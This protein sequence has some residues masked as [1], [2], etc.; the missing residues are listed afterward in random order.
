M[1]Y[2]GF[3]YGGVAYAG[4]TSNAGTDA[5]PALAVEVAFTTDPL[6]EPLW[7][8]ITSDVRS[9]ETMRGR[10]RELERFQPGRATIV[11]ANREA[12]YDSLNASGPHYGNLRPMK[13]IRI[14]ETFNGVT[15]P[16]FDGFVDKWQLDYP[17]LNKDSIAVL[18][19][20][21]G[22]KVWAR[23][24]MGRSVY[25]NEV[26]ADA[27]VLWWHL[28][29]DLG[30][31][32]EG[33]ALNSGSL[34]ANGNGTFVASPVVGGQALVVKDGGSSLQTKSRTA[35][36][37]I[38]PQGVIIDNAYLNL[39]GQSAWSVEG[40]IRLD[41]TSGDTHVVWQVS[42]PAVENPHAG[43]SYLN[44]GGDASTGFL[45][46]VIF[47]SAFTLGY[48]VQTAAGSILPDQTHHV[49]CEV[50]S[51]G[52]MVIFLDGN[53]VTTLATGA[54]ASTISG[55]TLPTGGD[56][57]LAHEGVA[58]PT[59]TVNFRG[60]SDEFAVYFSALAETRVD[61]HYAAGTAPWQGDSP[62]TRIGRALDLAEWP[63]TLRELDT[64]LTTFQSAEIASQ[65]VL[66][67]SQKSAES[68]YAGL[69][70]VTRD[71]KA[72]FVG[73]TAVF[74]RQPYAIPFGDSAG[75]VGYSGL[76]P[77]DGDEVI[78]NRAKVS[79]LNGAVRT[80]EDTV[81]ISEFSPFEFVLDGLLHNSEQGSTDYAFF[82]VDQYGE[83]RR[84]IVKLE[85]LT[86]IPGDEDLH[87]PAVLGVE[88]GDAITVRNNPIGGQAF[89]QVC[90]IEGIRQF[91]SPGGIHE[92]TFTLSPELPIR[93]LEDED[94]ATLG[95][96]EV[97][98]NQTG[99][100]TSATDLTNLS[101]TVTVGSGRRIRITGH[102]IFQKDTAAGYI[103]MP[104]REGATQL[105]EG[106]ET[107]SAALGFVTFDSSAVETPS[108]GSHTYKLMA[109]TENN[110][111]SLQASALLPAFILVEDIGPA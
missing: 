9:W 53:R 100:G 4:S 43:C 88:L 59:G 105:N 57:T 65:S 36:E 40:W 20:T 30:K 28:D 1:S 94:V 55:V 107:V 13:R 106:I 37:F 66:E 92:T 68:E 56:L 110:T 46:F 5:K 58:T 15:Y 61:A 42:D 109:M 25:A 50:E 77:D 17:G 89:E 60:L 96:A 83:Q 70:F 41:Q 81:S 80:Q 51:G 29:E 26:E 12:Q 35:T 82:V 85:L 6:A 7:E 62:G 111:C 8:D 52:Q 47:N 72:R 2:G 91:G 44:S 34:A 23:T 11:L 64:G 76:T 103:I 38:S 21:D 39:L 48:G 24:D 75:E 108:A 73:R 69:L 101:V 19:A 67:H 87:Y 45:R 98:A 86:P 74:G 95:Y 49:V 79:R 16:V 104:I 54:A 22:F 31:L 97:T 18:T 102:C 32:Q 93:A 84:R 63:S 14:R 90:V 78:R 10:N 71:G 99:I 33:S 27:P 3:P